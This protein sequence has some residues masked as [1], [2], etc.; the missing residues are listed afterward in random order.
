[1]FAGSNIHA[2]RLSCR[3]SNEMFSGELA[4]ERTLNNV[5]DI[6]EMLLDRTMKIEASKS[7]PH[8]Y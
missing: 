4:K 2:S 7:P 3:D 1:M 6:Q 5:H 8:K